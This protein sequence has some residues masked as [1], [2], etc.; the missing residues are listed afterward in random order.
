[1][2]KT[3]LFSLNLIQFDESESEFP[4]WHGRL[5]SFNNSL[6]IIGGGEWDYNSQSMIVNATVEEFNETMWD[7]NEQMSPV[8]KL[9]KIAFFSTMAI[10]NDLFIFGK[11]PLEST[12]DI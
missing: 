1:M 6:I 9:S 4:H 10:E 11:Y 12:I 3:E 2:T 5:V 8:N 7:E